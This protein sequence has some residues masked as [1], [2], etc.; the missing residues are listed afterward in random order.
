MY[1]FRS[2]IERSLLVRLSVRPLDSY[3]S[4]GSIP[5][6]PDGGIFKRAVVGVACPLRH[7]GLDIGHGGLKEL[8]D[9]VEGV[10]RVAYPT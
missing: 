8:V 2:S 1:S 3:D 6:P 5:L 10:V 7:P 9:L 4:R